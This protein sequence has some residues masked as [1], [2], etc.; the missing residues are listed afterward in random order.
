MGEEI[1]TL[2]SRARALCTVSSRGATQA[3]LEMC[4][5]GHGETSLLCVPNGLTSA[6]LDIWFPPQVQMALSL[7]LSFP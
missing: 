1:G 5:A 2:L 4:T 7:S 3:A 6:S